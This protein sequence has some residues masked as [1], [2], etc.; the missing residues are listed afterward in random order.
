MDSGY[1]VAPKK[2]YK[3]WATGGRGCAMKSR[4]K[5]CS[6]SAVADNG[7][8]FT[9]LTLRNSS[10]SA[11]PRLTAHLAATTGEPTRTLY[12]PSCSGPTSTLNTGRPINEERKAH[13]NV[14]KPPAGLLEPSAGCSTTPKRFT[15]PSSM[16]QVAD[17]SSTAPELRFS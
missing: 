10:K 12:V 7:S 4:R 2:A 15:C 3:A 17:S 9:K 14:L 6:A 1:L 16:F 13:R 5:A 11:M 8:V